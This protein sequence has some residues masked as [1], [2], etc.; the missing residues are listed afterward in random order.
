MPAQ[1]IA[2]GFN[3]GTQPPRRR[4][5]LTAA[6]SRVVGM[7]SV[8]LVDHFLGW[9]PPE[10][11]NRE[12]TWAAGDASPH[13]YF[14]YQV[15]A[16]H[17]ARRIGRRARLGVGVT[18][19]VRRHPVVIAQ[20]FLT[21]SHFARCRPILGIGAG[22]AENIVPYGLDFE[23]PVGR[24][25]E[26]LAVIRRCFESTGPIDFDGQFFHLDRALLDLAP[27]PAGTPEIWVAAHGPRTLALT[28]RYGDGWYPTIPMTADAYAASLARVHAAARTAGRAP[29]AITPAL[30]A[31]VVVGPDRRAIERSL[32][33]PAV[34]FL[35][36]LAPDSFWRAAG[37]EHPLGDGFRGMVD[38]IPTRYSRADIERALARIPPEMIAEQVI[39]GT[40]REVVA[41]LREL[42]EAGLR[43]VVLAPVSALASRRAAAFA[44]AVLPGMVRRLRSGR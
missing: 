16:G 37:L 29:E 18:E 43:H 9:W 32:R 42:G 8:W 30:Q 20:A 26:A 5:A 7:D 34:R 6:L 25:E 44:I 21:L 17:L 1:P 13:A 23:R 41:R 22:E 33:H 14:D 40:P 38:F 12:L 19:A 36:L 27:G 35:A 31:F 24:L 11:W 15:V 28:G 10:I 4:L 39:A 2:V 3:L